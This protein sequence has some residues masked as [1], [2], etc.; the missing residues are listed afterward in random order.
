MAGILPAHPVAGEV[1]GVEAL[2]RW[3][4][5]VRGL[6]SPLE[7]ISLAEECGLILPI[8]E[9]VLETAC[10]QIKAWRD[11][12][13]S[14]LWVSVNISARQFQDRNLLNMIQQTLIKTGLPSDALRL[15]I[16]ES[17]AMKD[18]PHS[19]KTLKDLSA[20]G[21]HASLDDFGDGYSSLSY[22]KSLPIRV[23]K[24]DRSFI[25]DMEVDKSSKA[26]ASAIISL[27]HSLDLDVVAEGVE[28]EEQLVFLKSKLCDEVQGYIFS[29][30]LPAE[31]LAEMLT[32]KQS[33]AIPSD[34]FINAKAVRRRK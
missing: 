1:V 11:R 26:I 13:R 18:F 14:R 25:Q 33:L 32:Y 16:T 27:G 30:P 28:N 31:K 24:I 21:I 23:L 10:A 6:V 19:V 3:L 15:E 2:V 22:L 8:G 20:L 5:P 34:Q 17:V 7:F 9:Y 4:H 12:G 29:Q